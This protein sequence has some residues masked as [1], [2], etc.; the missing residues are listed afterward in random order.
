ME[1]RSPRLLLRDFDDADAARVF[2]YQ[3]SPAYL[4]HYDGPAPTREEVRDLVE[5]FRRWAAEMPRTSYQLAITL[6]SYLIG[7]SGVRRHQNEPAEFGCELDPHFWGHGYALE[8]SA[9]LL[10]FA[11]NELQIDRVLA[12]TLPDN[13]AAIRLAEQLGF[14]MTASGVLVLDTRT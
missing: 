5:R 10:T 1:L 7:T 3:Q 11:R 2:E 13:R 6:D 8:A 4:E 9:T 12:R 14:T